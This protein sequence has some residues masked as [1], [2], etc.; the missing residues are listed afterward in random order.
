MKNEIQFNIYNYIKSTKM[1]PF[2]DI[3][4]E[5]LY[6]VVKYLPEYED[7]DN[8]NSIVNLNNVNN[9]FLVLKDVYLGLYIELSNI[10]DVDCRDLQLLYYYYKNNTGNFRHTY[11]IIF[12]QYIHIS[13]FEVI[14]DQKLNISSIFIK[15]ILYHNFPGTYHCFIKL[16]NNNDLRYTFYTE[17][18]L[19]TLSGLIYSLIYASGDKSLLEYLQTGTIKD[20]S[21]NTIQLLNRMSM[22]AYGTA[23]YVFLWL[24]YNDP[25]TNINDDFIPSLMYIVIYIGVNT[26]QDISNLINRINDD[27]INEMVSCM[28]TKLN[29]REDLVEY[30]RYKH[31]SIK[32]PKPCIA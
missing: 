31:V 9:W 23:N 21:G 10:Q 22:D 7:F 8:F 30:F 2:I 29:N 4:H 28:S 26:K 27:N 6:E 20:K 25:N 18:S 14:F 17:D 15:L 13:G 5:L 19:G 32:L 1:N 11:R 12:Y 16:I 3:P 24:Y